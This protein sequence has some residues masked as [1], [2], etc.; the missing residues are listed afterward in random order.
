[1]AACVAEEFQNATELLEQGWRCSNGLLPAAWSAYYSARLYQYA[2]DISSAIQPIRRQP[3]FLPISINLFKL[4]LLNC[5]ATCTAI[6]Q[7]QD[8]LGVPITIVRL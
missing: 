5:G 3:G 1:M 7:E 2:N 6:V 8:N 4:A